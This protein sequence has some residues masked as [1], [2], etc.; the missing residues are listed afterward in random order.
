M[1]EIGRFMDKLMLDH[2]AEGAAYQAAADWVKET[3]P[4]GEERYPHY[5][6]IHAAIMAYIEHVN[7]TKTSSDK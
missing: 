6:M 1:K 5:P 3:F 7:A 2:G 4:K